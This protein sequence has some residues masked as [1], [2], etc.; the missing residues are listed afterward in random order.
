MPSH[1]SCIILPHSCEVRYSSLFLRTKHRVATTIG[2]VFRRSPE[3]LI[4]C[5]TQDVI[6]ISSS[7]QNKIK[8]VVDLAKEWSCF[9]GLDLRVGNFI[10]TLPEE[11]LD[12]WER[13]SGE[14]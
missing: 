12:E 9:N 2:K 7:S 3:T 1:S 13:K 10:I 5:L 8:F 4:V 6:C 14:A 11:K